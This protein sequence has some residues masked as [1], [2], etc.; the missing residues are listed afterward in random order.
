MNV[1]RTWWLPVALAAGQLLLWPGLPVLRGAPPAAV[2]T[3]VA[4]VATGVTA[5][6]LG[7]RRRA[8]VPTVV[9]VL[10]AS[11][12]AQPTVPPDE[13]WLLAVAELVA[14]FSVAV[15]R[16]GRTT[17]LAVAG[18]SG[19]AVVVHL[20]RLGSGMSWVGE[21]VLVV[22]GYLLAAELGRSRR[23]WLAGRTVAAR[24]L[25]AADDE[26]RRAAEGERHRLARELHDVSAHHLTSIVVT[27]GAAERLAGRRPELVGEAL[28]F[29]ASTSRDTLTALH[30]LVAVMRDGDRDVDRP[31]AARLAELADGFR[32]LDQPVRLDLHLTDLPPALAETVH[33]LVREALTNVLR[34]A[35]GADVEV[36]VAVDGAVAVVEVTDDGRTTPGVTTV[37]AGRGIVGMR[38]RATALGGTLTAGPGGG[39]WRVRAELPVAAAPTPGR[40]TQGAIQPSLL[41]TGLVATATV[42]PVASAVVSMETEPELIGLGH[43]GLLALVVL[44]CAVHAAPLLWR[45]ERPWWT[46]VGVGV[47]T[48]LWPSAALTFGLP[49][50]ATFVLLIAVVVEFAAVYAV[51]A[52]ARPAVSWLGV[53]LAA[54]AFVGGLL[55][56]AAGDGS[57][58][59]EP[60]SVPVVLFMVAV[61]TVP[62]TVA[63]LPAWGAGLW[64]RRRR[65]LVLSR[66]GGALAATAARSVAVAAAERARIAEGL[67]TAVLDRAGR[68]VTVA[69]NGPP[70]AILTEARATLAA[71]RELLDDLRPDAGS[72]GSAPQPGAAEIAGL[73]AT[74]SGPGRRVTFDGP[75][76][77]TPLPVALDTSV[78]RLVEA[79]LEAAV[80]DVGVRLRVDDQ[81]VRLA[82]TGTTMDEVASAAA[83]ARV[84]ALG[85][86]L[87]VDRA[88]LQ[89]RLPVPLSVRTPVDTEPTPDTAENTGPAPGTADTDTGTA[90]PAG[91]VAAPVDA[92]SPGA[93]RVD[94]VPA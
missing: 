78:Y 9:V 92:G 83:Q 53:P 44:L 1:V 68:L 4:L 51:G 34:H 7:W 63:L 91:A 94:G 87:R 15:H 8:P 16:T 50:G 32:R 84:E 66:E 10:T 14:L 26:L 49:S 90:G 64:V 29:A 42:L 79:A 41:T 71:M 61:F 17:W 18:A 30:R 11:A 81:E 59:G 47:A 72:P 27:V 52:Y 58:G 77:V 3:A 24:R 75:E 48:A 35:R 5:L 40:P 2:P 85:G 46:L 89:A 25:V 86:Q 88:G 39:G 20:V 74:R 60:V 76:T 43:P 37:G 54:L 62:T 82:M 36:R 28:R 56:T 31:L 12:V 33:A 13:M 6:A 19:T 67:R 93:G 57:L 23:R 22:L 55:G 38:E 69:D 45:V 70:A 21:V 65:G 80:G 73:C